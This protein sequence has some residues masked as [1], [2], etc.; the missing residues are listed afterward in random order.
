MGGR[1]LVLIVA[2]W[3][4]RLEVGISRDMNG[5]PWSVN[6]SDGMPTRLRA[7]RARGDG[8]GGGFA[9]GIPPVCVAPGSPSGEEP[10]ALASP[11]SQC[12]GGLRQLDVP[13]RDLPNWWGSACRLPAGVNGVVGSQQTIDNDFLRYLG[14][15]RAPSQQPMMGSNRVRSAAWARAGNRVLNSQSWN[16]CAAERGE[17]PTRPMISFLSSS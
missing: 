10:A 9:E 14:G 2:P 1:G 8:L 16:C 3:G 13:P 4:G 11:S 12:W 5:V 17:S 6:I 15:G 7:G